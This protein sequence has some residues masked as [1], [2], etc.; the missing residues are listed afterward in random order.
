MKHQVADYIESLVPYVPGKS[1]QEVRR[2]YQVPTVIKLAS[3]ENPLGPS[4][5]AV[6]AIQEAMKDLHRYPDVTGFQL[7]EALSKHLEI[8]RRFMTLGNGS[9]EV[10]DTLI[11]TFCRSGDQ[12]VTP[13]YS[14]IA[15]KTCAQIHGVE[16]IEVNVDERFQF[17]SEELLTQ[18]KVNEKVK[19]VFLSNPNNPTGVYISRSQMAEVVEGLKKIRRGSVFLVLD[20][21]YWEYV[22]APDLPDPFDLLSTYSST[23]YSSTIILRTFSKIYG[24]AGL[25]VGYGIAEPDIINYLEKVRMPFN[26]NS[27]ALVGA[28]AALTDIAF[29]DRSKR[30]NQEGKQAWEAALKK[31]RIPFIPTQG[32]FIFANVKAGLGR[33][34]PEIFKDCLE[35][36][37][38]FRPLANY[39]LEDHL[40]ISIG[41]PE[42]NDAG[43]QILGESGLKAAI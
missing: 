24:L 14:F 25:R 1:I 36:G 3:N 33:S 21:A 19:M 43:I 31:L 7:K 28:E 2:E 38:V 39:G 34:G 11:R 27:L 42:E 20:Y 32:N 26:L 5:K 41:T 17:N 4:P 35:K 6:Q 18:V 16:T 15:Y 22:T 10:I 23:T 9:N 30:A 29:I 37:V 12:I 40:R 8:P 13:K